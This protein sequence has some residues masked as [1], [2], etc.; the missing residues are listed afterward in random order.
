MCALMLV[1]LWLEVGQ[2]I[3]HYISYYILGSHVVVNVMYNYL[4]LLLM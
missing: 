3:Y 1:G 4:F 2:L